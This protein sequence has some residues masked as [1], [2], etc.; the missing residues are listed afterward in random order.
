[1]LRVLNRP[2]LI[3]AGLLDWLRPFVHYDAGGR[4]SRL[5]KDELAPCPPLLEPIAAAF[6]APYREIVL[7][8]YRDGHATTPCHTDAGITGFSF[9]LSIGAPRTFRVHW[10]ADGCANVGRLIRC[11]NGTV[12]AMEQ[13]FQDECHHQL[14]ADPAVTEERLS[15]V[16]RTAPR[17]Q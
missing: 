8:C 17:E 12:V 2:E 5:L 16:F 3:T 14:A 10:I 13:R 6:P 15:L 1:M 9:I 4:C 11:E 7:Q